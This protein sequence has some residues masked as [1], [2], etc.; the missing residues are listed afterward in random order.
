MA[1]PNS[2]APSSPRE[3]PSEATLQFYM[4]P[5]LR[6]FLSEEIYLSPPIRPCDSRPGRLVRREWRRE[7]DELRRI[8][9]KVHRLRAIRGSRGGPPR[10]PRRIQMRI[11]RE[12]LLLSF[13]NLIKATLRQPSAG[14]RTTR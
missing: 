13:S 11:A 5:Y 12:R 7:S 8:A 10:R 4:T 3:R 6:Q 9:A 1:L 14:R 2:Q